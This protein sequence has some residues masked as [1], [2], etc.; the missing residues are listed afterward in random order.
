MPDDSGA[1]IRVDP[2]TGVQVIVSSGQFFIEPVGIAIV[3]SVP[4]DATDNGIV[5][6]GYLA[7]LGANW[8]TG[9]TWVLGDFNN[10]DT[11]DVG[12]L[13]ILGANW[14][15]GG[16]GG[17]DINVGAVPLPNALPAGLALLGG[18]ALQR[19]RG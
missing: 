5:D 9:T 7:R 8:G 1:I 2:D 15:G 12:D 3:P 6:V 4:G 16:A 17:A 11:V 14:T 18:F 13:A 10:D 19:R